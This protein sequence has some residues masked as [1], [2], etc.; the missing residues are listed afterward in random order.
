M[1]TSMDSEK[2]RHIVVFVTAPA[3]QAPDLARGVVEAGLAACVNIVPTIRSIYRWE[4]E[5]C[6][7]AEALLV[8][9]TRRSLFSALRDKLVALHPYDVPEVVALPLELGHTPYLEW[10]EASTQPGK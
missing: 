4:G 10:L 2:S 3:D 7:D 8:V 5:I 9:K 6:D 1:L